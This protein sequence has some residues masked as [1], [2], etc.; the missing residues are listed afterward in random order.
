MGG[1]YPEGEHNKPETAEEAVQQITERFNVSLSRNETV[2]GEN[3]HLLNFEPI[4]EQMPPE[5]SAAGGLSSTC[6]LVKIA[7]FHW[8]VRT[9]AAALAS[10]LR[11]CWNTKSILAWMTVSSLLIFLLGQQVVTFADLEP[12]FLSLEEAGENAEFDFL[13]PAVTPEGATLVDILDVR[14]TLVQ[15][16]TLPEDGS[17]SPS[18]KVSLKKPASHLMKV[19][20]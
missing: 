14:G 3:S 9:P 19:R 11:L 7:V 2:A 12:Q 10:S 15:R 8:L 16:Y 18:L 17:L 13:T 4:A 1:Q 5:F 6:G 20:P